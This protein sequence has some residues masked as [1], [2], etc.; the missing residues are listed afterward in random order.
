MKTLTKWFLVALTSV[1]I[2]GCDPFEKASSAAVAVIGA[3]ATDVNAGAGYSATLSGST[4]TVAAPATCVAPGRAELAGFIWVK[5]NVLL[6]GASVQTAPNNCTPAS[7]LALTSSPLNPGG[8]AWYACYNPQS[9]TPAEGPSVIIFLDAPATAPSGW[10]SADAFPAS[11]DTITPYRTTGT[12]SDTQGRTASFDVLLNVTP[13]PGAPT[14]P[15][16]TNFTTTTL[17]V[18]WK[19]PCTT[20]TTA[21]A[22]QRAPDV[23]G[24]P[25][26]WATVASGL[27]VTPTVWTDNTGGI[28]AGQF[29]WYRVIATTPAGNLTGGESTTKLGSGPAAPTFANVATTSLTVNWDALTDA[30]SYTVQRAPDV[31]GA[32]GTWTSIATGLPATTLTFDDTGLTAAT[33]YWYRIVATNPFST[34]RNGA[35]ATVTTL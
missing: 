14:A 25:G 3:G 12:V 20:T 31:S 13:D 5:F 7:T 10:I 4:W 17:D 2:V 28:T 11:G 15:T 16:F 35:S 9:P 27:P 8:D 24:A 22:V 26:T 34:S 1:A 23:A 21:Y 6:D 18:N 29:Y 30:G 19:A 32:P 33:K